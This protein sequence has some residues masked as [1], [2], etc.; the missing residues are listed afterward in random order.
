[1]H[2]TADQAQKVG[3]EADRRRAETLALEA[4]LDAATAA[5]A[6]ARQPTAAP[7]GSSQRAGKTAVASR[8]DFSLGAGDALMQAL[9]QRDD[10]PIQ[11]L[12]SL[13]ARDAQAAPLLKEAPNAAQDEGT[14]SRPT[15][16]P[17]SP[18]PTTAEVPAPRKASKSV[19]PPRIDAQ[20]AEALKKA[21]SAYALLVDK[22]PKLTTP[23]ANV[24]VVAAANQPDAEKID[25]FVNSLDTVMKR[26]RDL[27]K[28]LKRDMNELRQL[29]RK[30]E[31]VRGE[32]AQIRAQIETIRSEPAVTGTEVMHEVGLPQQA[33][34]QWRRNRAAIPGGAAGFIAP[35]LIGLVATMVTAVRRS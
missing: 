23:H 5:P 19:P 17:T 25:A 28:Q 4:A 7:A 9:L 26:Q 35:I 21:A 32:I 1:M 16:Q 11:A 33:A 22:H 27:G 34:N 2:E 20:T 13:P 29:T 8:S 15:P 6:A 31:K 10:E 30:A 18:P 12:D 14:T 3:L 24:N